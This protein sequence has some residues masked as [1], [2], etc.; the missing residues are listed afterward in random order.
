MTLR[1][2]FENWILLASALF[3]P[4]RNCRSAGVPQDKEGC[5][6]NLFHSGPKDHCG[7]LAITSAGTSET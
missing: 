2:R 3:R 7:P 6:N 4:V 1:R 5:C